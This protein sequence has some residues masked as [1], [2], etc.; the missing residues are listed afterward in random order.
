MCYLVTILIRTHH[1][2]PLPTPTNG[3]QKDNY[4]FYHSQLCLRIECAFGMFVQRW[5]ILRMTMLN[6]IRIKKTIALVNCPCKTPQF[7]HWQNDGNTPDSN[8]D[9]ALFEDSVNVDGCNS[10]FVPLAHNVEVRDVL[11]VD[12]NTPE[13][14]VGGGDHFDDIPCYC[15]CTRDESLQETQLPRTVLCMHVENMLQ[16]VPL[17]IEDINNYSLIVMLWYTSY[18]M[19]A[20]LCNYS[21]I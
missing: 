7:L 19:I 11:D 14:L 17:S 15:H 18:I 4:D 1:S 9:Q 16:F 21:V 3:G 10:G 13:A 2:W 8:F 5:R 20:H 12:I 6:G